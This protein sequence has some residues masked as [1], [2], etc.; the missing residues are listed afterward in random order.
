MLLKS[1]LLARIASGEVTVAFRY[2]RRPSVAAGG[3]LRTPAG[4]L[5]IDRLAE[6]AEDGISGADARRAGF[7]SRDDLMKSLAGG[8]GRI[9]YRIQF[10]VS[11]DD[12]RVALRLNAALS[13]ADATALIDRLS[14]LDRASKSGPWTRIALDLIAGKPGRT[15]AE[16]AQAPGMEKMPL[17]RRIRQLKA[18]GLTESLPVGYRLSPRGERLWSEMR[19]QLGAGLRRR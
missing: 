11:G 2:W 6:V 3:T 18:P 9:L 14:A 5:G 17:K 16:I 15:A 8:A 10:H 4:V 12:P 1:H 7:E 13:E 19:R